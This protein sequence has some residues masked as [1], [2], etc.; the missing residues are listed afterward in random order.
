MTSQS[1]Y[2]CNLIIQINQKLTLKYNRIVDCISTNL[3]VCIQDLQKKPKFCW[4]PKCLSM[5]FS[6]YYV[7]PFLY[8]FISGLQKILQIQLITLLGYTNLQI[9]L[10]T[11]RLTWFQL[12]VGTQP[13]THIHTHAIINNSL[14]SGTFKLISTQSQITYIQQIESTTKVPSGGYLCCVDSVQSESMKKWHVSY[15]HW[16]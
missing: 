14:W 9:K 7:Q 13:P 3:Q 12:G 2:I 4:K 1:T 10:M 15:L 8:I 5:G 16:I 11:F 6:N